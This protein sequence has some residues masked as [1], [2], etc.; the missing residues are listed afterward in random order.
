MIDLP[1]V[2]VHQFCPE[3]EVL[4][5]SVAVLLLFVTVLFGGGSVP[6]L[7]PRHEP[8]HLCLRLVFKLNIKHHKSLY[9]DPRLVLFLPFCRFGFVHDNFSVS[10]FSFPSENKPQYIHLTGQSVSAFTGSPTEAA[11][12]PLS[13][14]FL[15]HHLLAAAVREEEVLERAAAPAPELHHLSQPGPVWG[16]GVC[17]L[18]LGLQ[19][20]ADQVLEDRRAG[21]REAGRPPPQRLHRLLCQQRQQTV[22]LLGRLPGENEQ[23]HSLIQGSVK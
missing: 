9:P 5:S 8:V 11:H 12:T 16:G 15:R 22:D 4:K 21:G 7:D 3:E 1:G 18:L 20:H 6:T 17:R 19:H 23:Q 14:S 13:S 10:T 2:G